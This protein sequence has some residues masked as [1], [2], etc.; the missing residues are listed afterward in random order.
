MIRFRLAVIV[1]AGLSTRLGSQAS[2]RPKGLLE[3]SGEALLARSV[4]LLN[5]NGIEK[6]LVVVGDKRPMI[7]KALGNRLQYAFNPFFAGTNNM[8]SLWFAKT[9]AGDKPF[10]YLH[11]DI[12]Y[13]ENLLSSFIA[14]IKNGDA[15]SVDFGPTD[16]EAMK[17]RLANNRF[18]ES[19]K[20]IPADK[21]AGEWVGLAAFSDPQKLFAKIESLLEKN[22]LKDYDTLALTE[23]AAEGHDFLLIPTNGEPWMDIDFKKDLDRA[24]ELFL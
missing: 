19:S 2:D 10:L 7:E 1:A 5:R 21:S 20:D 12:I 23:M 22:H 24:R 15:L 4:R 11:G 3:V 16:A 9:W 17:V 13:S 14:G 8:A 18:I 6:I